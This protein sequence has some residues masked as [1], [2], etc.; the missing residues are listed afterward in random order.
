MFRMCCKYYSFV[1]WQYTHRSI[2]MLL[3]SPLCIHMPCCP[4]C[5]KSL[6][7]DNAIVQHMNQP[8]SCCHGWMDNLVQIS[9]LLDEA[10]KTNSEGI[11]NHT[12]PK[13]AAQESLG[14]GKEIDV[15]QPAD[16]DWPGDPHQG[17]VKEFPG[18]A[19][20]FLHQPNLFLN[21]FNQ[22]QFSQERC[23]NLYYPFTS[24]VDWEMT[25][26]GLSMAAINSLLSLEL[27]SLDFFSY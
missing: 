12:L 5:H 6:P 22:D 2:H 4:S 16:A 14:L 24:C 17:T 13:S 7:S 11:T 20:I 26:S 25:C 1:T 10:K 21:H 19:A 9:E 18:A 8:A 23:L 3:Y 27:V 15:D